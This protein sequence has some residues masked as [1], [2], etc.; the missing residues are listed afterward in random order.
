MKRI[1]ILLFPIILFACDGNFSTFFDGEKD[2]YTLVY[3]DLSRSLDSSI[4]SNAAENV[5]ELY[6]TQPDDRNSTFVVRVIDKDNSGQPLFEY[7]T[8]L[9]QDTRDF[10]IQERDSIKKEHG[11]IIENSILYYF[12]E[13]AINKK[14]AMESCIC[15]SLENSCVSLSSIDTSKTEIRLVVFSDMYEECSENS[16]NLKHEFYFC[17]NSKKNNKNFDSLKAEIQNKYSPDTTERIIQY[18]KPENLF[19]ILS[20]SDIYTLN[21]NHCL[22]TTELK[23]L[24][25][26]LLVKIGYDRTEIGVSDGVTYTTGLTKR[27]KFEDDE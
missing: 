3:I 14:S 10:K 23:Q 11:K 9:L 7:E 17:S 16:A 22:N 27:M 18:V 12:N 25:V 5:V 20:E 2:L 24:W 6:N 13:V 8:K 26:E 1:F 4:V 15:N 19:F 21:P